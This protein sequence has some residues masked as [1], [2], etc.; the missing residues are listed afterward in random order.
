MILMNSL[1]RVDFSKG[2]FTYEI[3]SL[4][5]IFACY[6]FF[7]NKATKYLHKLFTFISE[8]FPKQTE[9]EIVGWEFLSNGLFS[10]E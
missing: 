10:F 5:L 3:L 6:G 7:Q 1:S 8:L 2:I 4:L 9:I